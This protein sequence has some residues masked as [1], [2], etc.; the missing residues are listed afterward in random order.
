[1]GEQL[2]DPDTG[3]STPELA[4]L[5]PRWARG[6]SGTLI[7]GVC[8][9]ERANRDY[10]MNVIEADTDV[11]ALRE[12]VDGVHAAGSE[13]LCQLGHMGGWTPRYATA[14]PVAPSALDKPE[15]DPLF[16]ARPRTLTGEE[17]QALVERFATA[18]R[19]CQQAGADGV[20]LLATSWLLIGAFL[21]PAKNHRTD[22]WGAPWRAGPGSCAPSSSSASGRSPVPASRSG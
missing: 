2:A 19:V 17:V 9:V 3:D 16:F 20:E 5:Y 21:S 12:V 15:D 4:R 8:L 10:G 11:Q 14:Q 18:A 6:G 1:M 13:L 7:A 22:E